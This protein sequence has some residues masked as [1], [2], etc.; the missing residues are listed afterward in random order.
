MKIINVFADKPIVSIVNDRDVKFEVEVQ[1]ILDI[2]PDNVLDLVVENVNDVN[3]AIKTNI[4][5]RNLQSCKTGYGL[6]EY[7]CKCWANSEK[8]LIKLKDKE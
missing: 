1:K 2:V 6:C 7:Y 4:F 5:P 3:A 8:D